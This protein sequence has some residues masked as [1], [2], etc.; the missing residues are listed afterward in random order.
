MRLLFPKMQI[1]VF[2]AS[3]LN[4]QNYFA[5]TTVDEV[6]QPFFY[7]TLRDSHLSSFVLR[8]RN[9]QMKWKYW[10]QRDLIVLMFWECDLLVPASFCRPTATL[11]KRRQVVAPAV[12]EPSGGNRNTSWTLLES[13]DA[14]TVHP[15]SGYEASFVPIPTRPRGGENRSVPKKKPTTHPLSDDINNTGDSNSCTCLLRDLPLS[16]KHL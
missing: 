2:G 16:L 5:L 1:K 9:L 6:L 13:T 15:Q 10:R 8:G 11:L 4:D 14:A 3:S 12:S 7:C